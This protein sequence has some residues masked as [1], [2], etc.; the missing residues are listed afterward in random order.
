M[1]HLKPI[2]GPVR[3]GHRAKYQR[4]LTKSCDQRYNLF[5]DRIASNQ[6]DVSFRGLVPFATQLLLLVHFK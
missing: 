3:T 5:N 2:L 4:E 6:I 1:S